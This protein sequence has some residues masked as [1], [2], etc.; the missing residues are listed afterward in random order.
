MEKFHLVRRIK[1]RPRSVRGKHGDNSSGHSIH[2]F[3]IRAKGRRRRGNPGYKKRAEDSRRR[4][5]DIYYAFA[6]RGDRDELR[7][8]PPHRRDRFDRSLRSIPM[9]VVGHSELR[10]IS[11]FCYSGNYLLVGYL[12]FVSFICRNLGAEGN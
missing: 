8:L 7:A 6:A 4:T 5:R 10:V 11:L 1:P 2:R 3:S 9:R 12:C